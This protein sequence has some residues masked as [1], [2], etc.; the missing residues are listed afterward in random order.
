[1][2]DMFIRARSKRSDVPQEFLSKANNGV[3]SPNIIVN[4]ALR[5][6]DEC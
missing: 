5:V 4:S 3:I 1:M 6:T 2:T